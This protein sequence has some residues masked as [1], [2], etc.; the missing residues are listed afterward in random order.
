MRVTALERPETDA[1]VIEAAEQLRAALG[2]ERELSAILVEYDG[3]KYE[4]ASLYG[5]R[6]DAEGAAA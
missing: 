5:E 4:R 1:A 3:P 2:P 6:G